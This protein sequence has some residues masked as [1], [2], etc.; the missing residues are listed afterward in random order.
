MNHRVRPFAALAAAS[1]VA[2]A[3]APPLEP[4]PAALAEPVAPPPVELVGPTPAERCRDVQARFPAASD[5]RVPLQR[6]PPDYP[7]QALSRELEGWCLMTFDVAPDG[8]VDAASVS[9]DCTFDTFAEPSKRAV[10]R[11]CF[12]PMPADGDPAARRGLQ[13]LIEFNIYEDEVAAP[14]VEQP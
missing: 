8:V 3:C 7:V 2:V 4:P 12:S 1:L 13:S 14:P 10:T 11:W 9:A 5:D 6:I